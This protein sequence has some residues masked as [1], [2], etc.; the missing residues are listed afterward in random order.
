MTPELPA[1]L[2]PGWHAPG[3]AKLPRPTAFPAVVA[4]G[5][6]LVAFGVETSWLVS[7]AGLVLFAVGVGGWV[8]EMRHDRR[9]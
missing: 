3:P 4:L 7:A 9:E 2:P 5:A 8:G 1:S 6:C